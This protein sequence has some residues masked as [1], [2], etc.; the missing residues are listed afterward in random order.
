MGNRQYFVYILATYRNGTLYVGVTNDILRRVWEH[1][2]NVVK[3]F[4]SRYNI[5]RLVYCEIF[6]DI[7]EAISMEK[8]IK[9]GSRQKKLNL[10]N[11]FNP[12]WKDLYDEL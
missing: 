2:N 9:G 10:I 7:Y 11:K 4:T 5:H 12:Q 1:K 3:G 6:E 8:Q